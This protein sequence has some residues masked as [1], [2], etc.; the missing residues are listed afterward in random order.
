MRDCQANVF[1]LVIRALRPLARLVLRRIDRQ[2][3][4]E[5][6]GEQYFGV[7]T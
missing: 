7:F 4:D 3:L 5:F 1:V 2:I 6:I